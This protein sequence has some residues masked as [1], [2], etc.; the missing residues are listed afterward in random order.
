M[1][2]Q[3]SIRTALKRAWH[4][5]KTHPTFFL[6][7]SVVMVILNVSARGKGSI[8]VNIVAV[9]AAIIWSYVWLSAAL[10]AVDGKEERLT[11]RAIGTHFP[12]FRQVLKLLGVELLAG[13]IIVAGTILLIIPGI[14]CVVR[15]AFTNLSFVDRQGKIR[16]TVRY[17]WN[18]VKGGT[19]WTV[20]LVVIVMAALLLLGAVFFGIGLLLT[21]PIA[22]LLLTQLYRELTTHH[23]QQIIV[24]PAEIAQVAA[25]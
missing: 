22:I 7:L 15:L 5:Y 2:F 21:Y 10:A 8:L 24:Q 20:L 4:I 11:I 14:Y 9:A 1:K 25:E 17:S 18:L 23:E 6:L 12:S 19:F 16:E 3:F 13:L